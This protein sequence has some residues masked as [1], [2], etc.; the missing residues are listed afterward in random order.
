MEQA[1]QRL[2]RVN[3]SPTF[4]TYPPAE[5]QDWIFNLGMTCGKIVI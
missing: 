4:L 3:S 1:K 5:S 2:L